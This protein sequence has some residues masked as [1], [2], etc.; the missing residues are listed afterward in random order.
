MAAAGLAAALVEQDRGSTRP[1]LGAASAGGDRERLLERA[2]RRGVPGGVGKAGGG[3]DLGGH[4]SGGE[5]VLPQG[6]CPG[7]ADGTGVGCSEVEL[8][9]EDVGEQQQAVGAEPLGEESGCEVLV[10][11][12]VDA[13]EVAGVVERNGHATPT[14]GD[15]DDAA[16]DEPL[17]RVQLGDGLWLG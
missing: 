7:A 9:S 16:V 1:Y 17:D 10:D 11:D 14:G 3:F 12:G 8:H 6:V 13:A 4:R 2:D 15:D 5:P